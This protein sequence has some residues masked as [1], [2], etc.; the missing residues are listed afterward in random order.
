MKEIIG[1]IAE[2]QEYLGKQIAQTGEVKFGLR[3]SLSELQKLR[4]RREQT[5]AVLA[6]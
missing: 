4:M 3:I 5:L 2:I 1:K 6:A